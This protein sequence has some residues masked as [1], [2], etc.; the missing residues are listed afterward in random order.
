MDFAFNETP[1][2]KALIMDSDTIPIVSILYSMTEIIQKEV[3][4]VQQLSDSKRDTLPH[5]SAV[6]LIR[7]TKENMELLRNELNFPKYGKYYLYFTNFLDTTQLTL[8]SHADVHEVVQKVMEVYVDYSPVNDDLFIT[9]TPN[10]YSVL[11]SDSITKEKRAI[12]GLTSLCLSLR[13]NPSIRYQQNS[14]LSK[15][16]A[17]GLT[18]S[19]DRERKAFGSQTGTTLLILDR[20]F[21]PITP[22]LTQWTYQ[23]MIHE[24][25]GITNG[26]VT[27]NG[28]H[29]ILSNDAFYNETMYLL[30]SD[31]TDQIIKN[32]NALTQHAGLASK[33]YSSL[34]EMKA[35]IEAIPQL[36]KESAGVKKHLSIMNEINKT[37]SQRKLLDV[38]KLEQEIVCGSGKQELYNQVIQLLGGP[39]SDNDKLRVALLYSLKYEEKA[40]DVIEELIIKG[41]QREKAKLIEVILKYAGSTKRPLEIFPKVKSMVNFVKKSVA[42]VENVFIQHKPVLESL[43][44][45]LTNQQL[46]DKFPYCRGGNTTGHEFIIYI[47][48]GV[49]LEEEL[50]VATRNRTN[51]TQHFIIGGSDLLNTTKY[52]EQLNTMKK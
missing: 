47:V 28:T 2:M 33:Q 3:F 14:E 35:T 48:G 1:G 22:L 9:S 19:L 11:C 13:K 44:D 38:S 4:L 20:I 39:Y 32:V 29:T 23:A 24:F 34:E 36:K 21:D 26:K 41:V 16:I 30:F 42:G 52:L 31:I 12:D 5:L 17:E 51:Q 49:T 7:P 45:A 8:L 10:Y 25:L 27:I 37:V 43:L 15:R 50:A 46:L 40:N 6:C 18:Q